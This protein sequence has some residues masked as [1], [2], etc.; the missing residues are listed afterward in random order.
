MAYYIYYSLDIA[1]MKTSH[2]NSSMAHLSGDQ[3]EF[4]WAFHS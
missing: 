1:A 3:L 2:F 4:K